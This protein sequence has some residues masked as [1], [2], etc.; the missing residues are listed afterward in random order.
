MHLTPKPTCRGWQPSPA[1]PRLIPDSLRP[2]PRFLCRYASPSRLKRHC[3]RGS[4]LPPGAPASAY[5]CT[6]LPFLSV[7]CPCFPPS[8]PCC[9][10]WVFWLCYPFRP[11]LW[12]FPHADRMTAV[13]RRY[14]PRQHGK[15]TSPTVLAIS[16]LWSGDPHHSYAEGTFALTAANRILEPKRLHEEQVPLETKPGDATAAGF[17]AHCPDPP[18]RLSALHHRLRLRI[19]CVLFAPRA[20][21]LLAAG[22]YFLCH[23]CHHMFGGLGL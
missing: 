9:P 20:G 10:V 15:M 3:P 14:G 19:Q 8:C 11:R 17:R 6:L 5:T 22:R 7:F 21:S 4:A 12:H 2:R 18:H 16:S 23:C 13:C 1:A